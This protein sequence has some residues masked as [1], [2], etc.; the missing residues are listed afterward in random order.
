MS[1]ETNTQEQPGGAESTDAKFSRIEE[2]LEQVLGENKQLKALVDM[3]ERLDDVD[4]QIAN[5]QREATQGQ[6]ADPNQDWNAWMA[7]KIA[8]FLAERDKVIMMLADE[9]DYLKTEKKFPEL[10]DEEFQNDVN[11]FIRDVKK[12]RG[13]VLSRTDAIIQIKGRQVVDGKLPAGGAAPKK[14]TGSP[15]ESG[16][17]IGTTRA[18][19]EN[20]KKPEDMSIEELEASMRGMRI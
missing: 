7:P 15:V 11:K 16:G 5:T 1:D 9:L 17:G 18:A 3:K 20:T 2:R 10:A 6:Q 4:Q 14:V 13:I 8:P 12:N 19:Q